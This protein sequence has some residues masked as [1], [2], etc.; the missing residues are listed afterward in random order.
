MNPDPQPNEPVVFWNALSGAL[1]ATLNVVAYVLDWSEEVKLLVGV[2]LGAWVLVA[3]LLIRRH[4]TTFGNI[5]DRVGVGQAEQAWG[6]RPSDQDSNFYFEIPHKPDTP[7][8]AILQITPLD[9]G[10]NEHDTPLP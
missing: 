6:T 2:M 9:N 10:T 5:V 7:Q 4:T 8:K 3:S 1:I